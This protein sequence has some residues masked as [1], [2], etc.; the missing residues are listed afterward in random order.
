MLLVSYFS[1][2]SLQPLLYYH[3]DNLN[4][5]KA[6]LRLLEKVA[7]NRK[8]G[9]NDAQIVKMKFR[10]NLDDFRKVE[11][12]VTYHFSLFFVSYIFPFFIC[13]FVCLFI[14]FLLCLFLCFFIT[15]LSFSGLQ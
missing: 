7:I 2:I 5:S 13:L 3:R 12:I 6:E 10:K 11:I 8:I 14:S 15:F 1:K 4:K 9:Q